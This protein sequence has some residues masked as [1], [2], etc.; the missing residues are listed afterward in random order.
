MLSILVGL[1]TVENIIL[2]IAGIIVGIIFGAIPG[3]SSTMAI[4]LFLPVTFGLEVKSAFALLVALYIGGVSGGFISAILIN[5]PGSAMSIATTY[6]GSPMVEKGEAHKAL[7]VA[8]L[9][10]TL[11]TLVSITVLMMAA[12]PLAR[13]ALKLSSYDYF[14]LTFLSLTLISGVS[15]KNMLMGLTS[16]FIGLAFSMVGMAPIDGV[17]RFTFGNVQLLNGFSLLPAV[18]GLFA[19][20]EIMK[21]ATNIDEIP[22]KSNNKIKIK[23]FGIT[24]AEFFGQMKNFV[25]ASTLGLLVG[26][27]PGMGGSLANQVSYAAVQKTSK[28]P[29]KFGTG[30]I[31]G[32]IASETANNA[33]IGGAMIPLLALGI[34]GDGPTAMLLGAFMIHG[35]VPG[36]LLFTTNGD[37]VNTIFLALF[38]CTFLMVIIEYFGLPIFMKALDIPRGMLLPI[39]LILCSVGAFASNN[40][41][42]DIWVLLFF[43]IVGFIMTK[44]DIPRAPMVLGFVLGPTVETNLRRSVQFGRGSLAPFFTNPVSGILLSICI[45]IIVF[46]IINELKNSYYNRKLKKEA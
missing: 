40:N 45:L 25:I 44:L 38:V 21:A 12:P 24:L 23:G 22:I 46:S 33:S 13:V 43:G 41:M 29:R 32:V 7:G 34:P 35:L 19:V 42:F 37:L 18:V 9:F 8:I 10:S 39:I 20:T 2:M 27:L 6:D 16:G 14:A 36:P 26:F 31:D 17:A 3:L 15:G 30:I 11:G 4:A 1:F 28:Y 5:I